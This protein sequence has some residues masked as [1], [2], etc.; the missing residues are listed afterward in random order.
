MQ[1]TDLTGAELQG[2][3][4]Y[5]AELQAANLTEAELQKAASHYY[6]MQKSMISGGKQY[7]GVEDQGFNC[8]DATV[9]LWQISKWS[10]CDALIMSFFVMIVV[11]SNVIIFVVTSF[12]TSCLWERQGR[13]GIVYF[14][15]LFFE[16]SRWS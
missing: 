13:K 15:F 7:Q 6:Y 8:G 16:I 5:G 12:V 3:N 4:L 11:S 10:S 14:Q 9:S 2:A 1:G